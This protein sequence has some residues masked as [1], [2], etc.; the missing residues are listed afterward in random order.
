MTATDDRLGELR[1]K[2][3]ENVARL[4]EIEVMAVDAVIEGG[5]R[6]V[7][8]L[9]VKRRECAERIAAFGKA[10][11]HIEHQ[12]QIEDQQRMLA[13][14]IAAVAPATKAMDDSLAKLVLP[15]YTPPEKP[16][17]VEPE[18]PAKTSQRP[19][20]NGN[21]MEGGSRWNDRAR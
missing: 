7:A 3:S 15:P 8:A 11:A 6:D 1:Q 5:E 21:P 16:V 10:I 13:V 19:W 20:Y 12:K 9:E 14:S 4:S 17:R 18:V 2:L